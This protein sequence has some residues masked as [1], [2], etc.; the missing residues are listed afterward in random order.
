MKHLIIGPGSMIIYAFIGAIKYLKDSGLLDDLHEI[1]CSSAGAMIGFFYVFSKG[2]VD[3]LLKIAL[4]APLADMAKPDIKSLLTKFGLIDAD[5]F[6][7]FMVKVT[8]GVNPSF[9]ELYDINPIKLHIPTYDI[10]MN[11]TI[12]MSVDTTPDMKVAHAVRRSIAVPIIMTPVLSRYIDGS[13]A[14]YSPYAPFLGKQDVFEIRFT[15][16]ITH[17]KVPKNFFQFLYGVVSALISTRDVYLDFPRLDIQTSKE[18]EL[19]NFSMDSS[20]KL[21]LYKNGYYQA[22]QQSERSLVYCHSSH[23]SCSEDPKSPA[24]THPPCKCDPEPQSEDPRH[25]EDDATEQTT[26]H[27]E[28]SSPVPP[29]L[30]L[31]MFEDTSQETSHSDVDS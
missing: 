12:Y 13:V 7:K 18:F 5:R 31:S 8:G 1:S 21:Q 26:D 2:D 30:N 11:K 24:L 9:K 25:L 27:H 28:S 19:F 29:E 3:K 20:Q 4:D 15:W 10:V 22:K 23:D 16:E 6:E 17:R 14:E